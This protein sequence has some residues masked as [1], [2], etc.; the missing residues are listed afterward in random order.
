MMRGFGPVLLGSGSFFVNAPTERVSP[1]FVVVTGEVFYSYGTAGNNYTVVPVDSY[2]F[3]KV[4]TGDTRLVGA[5]SDEN[6]TIR[7]YQTNDYSQLTTL[8]FGDIVTGLSVYNDSKFVACSSDLIRYYSGDS[9]VGTPIPNSPTGNNDLSFADEDVFAVASDQLYVYEWNGTNGYNSLAVTQSSTNLTKVSISGDAY[10][11]ASIHSGGVSIYTRSGSTYSETQTLSLTEIS[12]LDLTDDGST[13][14]LV[15]GTDSGIVRIYGWNG[16]AFVEQAPP[17]TPNSGC[18]S[19]SCSGDRFVIGHYMAPF[20]TVYEYAGGFYNPVDQISGIDN[21]PQDI[22]FK[23]NT[24]GVAT[25][26][27]MS[28]IIS[29]PMRTYSKIPSQGYTPNMNTY[30]SQQVGSNVLAYRIRTT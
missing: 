8:Q 5:Q 1:G 15:G 17:V 24:I 18:L 9:F 11:V 28:A 27:S 7:V 25:G 26:N 2:N 6:G 19:V 10:R 21:V 14:V 23:R 22:S 12:D 16:S 29:S 30:I 13:L 4:G 3:I 20:V